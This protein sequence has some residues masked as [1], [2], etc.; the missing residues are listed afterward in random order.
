MITELLEAIASVMISVAASISGVSSDFFKILFE[1][2]KIVNSEIKQQE[3]LSEKINRLTASLHESSQLMNE[4]EEEFEKQKELLREFAKA[5]GEN[6][7]AKKK[8]FFKRSRVYST[9]SINRTC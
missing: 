3:I 5:C 6:N 9:V 7:Y 1:K 2:R 4:I 8:S